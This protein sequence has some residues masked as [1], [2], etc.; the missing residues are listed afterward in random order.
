M[1]NFSTWLVSHPFVGAQRGVDT[2]L[3]FLKDAVVSAGIPALG[4]STHGTTLILS[5]ILAVILAWFTRA[6]GKLATVGTEPYVLPSASLSDIVGKARSI[7]QEWFRS[8]A[9]I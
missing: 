7:A 2:V 5:A 6:T 9:Y 3:F 4:L 8:F 1:S